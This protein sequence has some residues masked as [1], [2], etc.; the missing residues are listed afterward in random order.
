MT[1]V[2]PIPTATNGVGNIRMANSESTFQKELRAAIKEWGGFSDKN[3]TEMGAKGRPDLSVLLPGWPHQEWELKYWQ[4][5]GKK[6][7]LSELQDRWIREYLKRGGQ[8]AMVACVKV[9]ALEW[10]VWV[11][12]DK[13][14][15]DY[16]CTRKRGESWSVEAIATAVAFVHDKHAY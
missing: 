15:L 10:Q 14:H 2:S 13:D 3:A 1:R 7:D 9:A 16:V 11:G 5:G 6:N 8:V 4:S 12:R